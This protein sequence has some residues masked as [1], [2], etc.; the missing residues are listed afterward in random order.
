MS[1]LPD[2]KDDNP[3]PDDSKRRGKDGATP[4][5]DSTER[6]PPSD[7]ADHREEGGV[8]PFPDRPGEKPILKPID[9]LT[10][11]A[12]LAKIIPNSADIH[13]MSYH[14]KFVRGFI[15]AHWSFCAAK[16]TVAR[17]GKVKALDNAFREAETWFKAADAW[18]S[19]HPKIMMH[20]VSDR[21]PLEVTHPNCGRLMR[22]MTSYDK[23]FADTT[24]ALL[25]RSILNT[26]RER[27]LAAAER[28]FL[29]IRRLCEPDPSKFTNDGQLIGETSS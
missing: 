25:Q 6:K 7:G 18:I 11:D 28:R 8:I 3:D 26:D 12:R 29:R 22:L 13:E 21:F 16:F 9:R 2:P 27:A 4:T 19:E 14:S 10:G 17:R 1:A 24:F 20:L 5:P 23:L 15:K